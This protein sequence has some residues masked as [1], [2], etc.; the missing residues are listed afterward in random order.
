MQHTEYELQTFPRLCAFSDELPRLQLDEI[1]Q[2]IENDAD[3]IREIQLVYFRNQEMPE[4]E[5]VLKSALCKKI[6]TVIGNH[7]AVM[8]GLFRYIKFGSSQSQA[9]YPL[10]NMISASKSSVRARIFSQ[11]GKLD[12]TEQARWRSHFWPDEH[13]YDHGWRCALLRKDYS[14]KKG[15]ERKRDR[16]IA[17]LCEVEGTAA[18]VVDYICSTYESRAGGFMGGLH[19]KSKPFTKE[20]GIKLETLI[21]VI[22]KWPKFAY[23]IMNA[24]H[25]SEVNL[26]YYQ[27][28]FPFLLE[29]VKE[30]HAGSLQTLMNDKFFTA[31]F[32]E[33]SDF[34]EVM[35]LC[36]QYKVYGDSFIYNK[37]LKY[38]ADI[39]SGEDIP[40]KVFDYCV[41]GIVNN[42]RVITRFEIAYDLYQKILQGTTDRTL[43]AEVRVRLNDPIF[44]FQMAEYYHRTFQYEKAQA[45]YEGL[46]ENGQV[47]MDSRH[48]NLLNLPVGQAVKQLKLT[49]LGHTEAIVLD[50]GREALMR[51]ALLWTDRLKNVAVNPASDSSLTFQM[52]ERFICAEKYAEAFRLLSSI[53]QTSEFY[54]TSQSKLRLLSPYKKECD[55]KDPYLQRLDIVDFVLPYFKK[56]K[57]AGHPDAEK[58][59]SELQ[60]EHCNLRESKPAGY[61]PR[62]VKDIGNKTGDDQLVLDEKNTL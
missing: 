56:A 14:G 55:V 1:I 59:L 57:D 16:N 33:G 17:I 20:K 44:R 35:M 6:A 45:F 42:K 8:L 26:R 31:L 5:V 46:L 22:R 13:S 37:Q 62:F 15:Q 38:F 25:K 23:K 4:E 60:A 27:E 7:C 34:S 21:D 19:S 53:P 36:D 39:L 54:K 50:S 43:A 3:F 12:L 30:N 2:I 24:M 18:F 41:Q 29:Q 51:L 58:A 49:E 32:V 47:V 28:L 11:Y 61:Q 48:L 9:I 40:D 52:A 10:S